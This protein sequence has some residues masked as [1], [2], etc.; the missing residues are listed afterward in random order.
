MEIAQA[1]VGYDSQL[2]TGFD[3]HLAEYL[4]TGSLCQ[5]LQDLGQHVAA[6]VA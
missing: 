2:N 3:R 6:P 4:D 5:C 1:Q